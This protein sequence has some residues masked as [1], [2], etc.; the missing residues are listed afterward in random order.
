MINITS[1]NKDHIDKA[2]EI[3]LANYKEEK[4]VVAELPSIDELPDFGCFADNGLGV[5]MFDDNNMLGFLCCYNPWDHAFDSTAR[6][7]FSPIHAHGAVWKNRGMIYKK[8]YQSAA[9]KWVE[10]GI[11]YHAIGLYAHDSQA[12]NAF[13]TYGFGLRCIDAIRPMVNL[14]CISFDGISFD[15]ITKAD[16]KKIR[17]LRRMHSA[18]MGES[19]CFMK[20]S[21]DNV[22]AWLSRAETR[23]SRLFIA[24]SNE[25]IIAYIEIMNNG[26]NFATEDGNMK[27]ICGAFCLPEYRGKGIAQ[28][29][30]N[31]VTSKLNAEGYKTLGVDFEGFNPTAS[32]FWLK[33]FTA[34]TNGVVRR[35]DECV[36]MN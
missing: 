18:H 25:K 23:D 5:A 7:T 24:S 16:V 9:K 13:F 31:F 26:E 35:I 20:A 33:H 27:N 28:G 4:S 17:K 14:E 36:L 12:L 1:F 21:P 15:E 10:C 30:L 11:T 6:G 22:Q 19:P 34:Y 8:L 3:A 29:L 32:G 2:T